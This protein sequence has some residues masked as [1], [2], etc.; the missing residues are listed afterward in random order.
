VK[1]LTR[2]LNEGLVTIKSLFLEGE[3]FELLDKYA[4]ESKKKYY[5]NINFLE[6]IQQ[7]LI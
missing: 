6:V 5:H 4:P 7:R 3:K 2:I 1:C